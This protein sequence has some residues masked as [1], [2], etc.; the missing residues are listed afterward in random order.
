ML[1]QTTL[2]VRASAAT[3]A[4]GRIRAR[5]GAGQDNRL[6]HGEQRERRSFRCVG[7]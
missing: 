4:D 3:C 7:Q 1:H 6:G 2:L 5:G